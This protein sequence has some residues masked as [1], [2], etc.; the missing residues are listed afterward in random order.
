MQP[1][2]LIDNLI[3]WL[4]TIRRRVEECLKELRIRDDPKLEQLNKKTNGVFGDHADKKL[5]RPIGIPIIIVGSKY[6]QFQDLETS[7][8]KVAC[9][10]LR[11]I[12][13]VNGCSLVF[14]T[15][16]EE[17]LVT[18]VSTDHI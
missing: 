17:A 18:R 3:T 16:E 4:D 14:V 7:S 8:K 13:L 2:G 6:D 11:Y 10:T 1:S 12:A 15:K 9:K 5:I